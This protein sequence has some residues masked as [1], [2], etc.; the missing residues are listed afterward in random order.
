MNK[1]FPTKQ[2]V[3][4]LVIFAIVIAILMEIGAALCISAKIFF[5]Y[6][7]F[8]TLLLLPF[9]F[10]HPSRMKFGFYV[11]LVASL[12]ILYF[13]PWNSRKIFLKDFRKVEVGMTVNEVEQIMSKY[14][15]GTGWPAM[16]ESM[17]STGTLIHAGSM[18]SRETSNSPD[19]DLVIRDSITYRHDKDG[20]FDSDWGIVKFKKG[21]V[22]S[23]TFSPD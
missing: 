20:A 18:V 13:I 6:G 3:V 7:L 12:L 19:G 22:V 11:V 17:F 9:L 16:P 21:K 5:R 8:W 2:T 4:V 1:P 10:L 14:I 15:K 23:T